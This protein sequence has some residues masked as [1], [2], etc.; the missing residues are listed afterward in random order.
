MSD[1]RNGFGIPSR[2]LGL[3]LQ[4]TLSTAA[5]CSKDERR[6]VEASSQLLPPPGCTTQLTVNRD[7]HDANERQSSSASCVPAHSCS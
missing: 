6:Q 1:Q 2:H 7:E 5:Y 4:G 3:R